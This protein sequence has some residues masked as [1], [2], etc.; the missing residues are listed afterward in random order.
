MKKC[1]FLM[2]F[3]AV[4]SVT[5]LAQDDVEPAKYENVT[6]HQVVMIDFEQGKTGR[7]KE[8][9]AQFEKA[10]EEAGT[11]SP[12]LYWLSTGE[13]DAMAIWKLD[14]GP[15]DLEWRITPDDV[16]WWKAFVKQQG[17]EEAANKLQDEFGGLV[18][19]STS[20][21]SRKEM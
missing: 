19:R 2:F 6:W 7:A 3:V 1:S 20:F 5:S 16:K 9:I 10:G 12:E 8:I 21:L 13:Y 14:N 17:S 15:A 11:S 4:L 18:E